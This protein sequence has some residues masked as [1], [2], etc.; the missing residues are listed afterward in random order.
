MLIKRIARSL[1]TFLQSR[2]ILIGDV[3]V[4][5]GDPILVLVEEL[6]IMRV[7]EHAYIMWV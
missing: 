7:N 1:F 3:I 4:S 2:L 5:R 6:T